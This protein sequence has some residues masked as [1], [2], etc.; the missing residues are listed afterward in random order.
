MGWKEGCSCLSFLIFFS[1]IKAKHKWTKRPDLPHSP[2]TLRLALYMFSAR[3]LRQLKAGWIQGVSPS[4]REP[5]HLM[6]ESCQESLEPARIQESWSTPPAAQKHIHSP[7]H[8]GCLP[9][10]SCFYLTHKF[11]SNHWVPTISQILQTC[12]AN[13]FPFLKFCWS[14]ADVECCVNFCYIAKCFTYMS[15]YSFSYS[16]PLWFLTGYWIQFPMLYVVVQLLSC[17]RLWDPMDCSTPVLYHLLKYLGAYPS[18]I[19]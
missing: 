9:G 13:L 5:P 19:Y 10:H 4:C 18:C 7:D 17:V 2:S 3:G 12:H 14:I 11:T 8:H 6:P 16:S 15:I 1:W